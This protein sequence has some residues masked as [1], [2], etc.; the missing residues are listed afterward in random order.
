M[1]ESCGVVTPLAFLEAYSGRKGDVGF[2]GGLKSAPGL[3]PLVGSARSS[4]T[5]IEMVGDH[6]AALKVYRATVRA[7][8][9]GAIRLLQ[10]ADQ[11]LGIGP[12]GE[13]ISDLQVAPLGPALLSIPVG[14]LLQGMRQQA[15]G[16][17]AAVCRTSARV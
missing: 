10:C 12:P 3:A 9:N 11:P 17:V 2:Q 6:V 7:A 4:P 1:L 15:A 14:R 16:C 8:T 13:P 5:V